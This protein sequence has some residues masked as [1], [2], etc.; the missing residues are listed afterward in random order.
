MI[1]II[2]KED[3]YTSDH[4]W[5][6]SRFLFSFADYYDPDNMSFGGMRVFN[7]DRIAG[8]SGFPPHSHKEMEIVTILHEGILT[9]EDSMGNKREL[10]AGYVQRM[11]AGTGVTHSEMNHRKEMVSLYQLWFLPQ[12]KGIPPSYEEK[13]FD[14]PDIRKKGR[15]LLVSKEGDEG[16]VTINAQVRIEYYFL[17]KGKSFEMTIAINEYGLLYLASGK[18]AVGRESLE[19]KDH[20]RVVNEKVELFAR[21][22]TFFFLIVTK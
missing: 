14:Y 5:L 17:E 19:E 22:E 10:K 11:S 3:V 15:A 16:S 9:H 4:G 13:V 18:L 6:T 7:D 12:K 2:K 21:E 20:L 1:T 8:E